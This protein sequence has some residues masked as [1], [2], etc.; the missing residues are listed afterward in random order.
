MSQFCGPFLRITLPNGA[1]LIDEIK[2]LSKRYLNH[3][4][5]PKVYTEHRCF[6][7]TD[8]FNIPNHFRPNWIGTV[9]DPIERYASLYY[10]R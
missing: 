1:S 3:L 9:R 10:F 8:D 4:N 2:I 5:G 6:V 7:N